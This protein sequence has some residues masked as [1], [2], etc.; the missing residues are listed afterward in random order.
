MQNTRVSKKY[1]G[2]KYRNPN[3]GRTESK[4]EK[5]FLCY[6]STYFYLSNELLALKI[7]QKV[8]VQWIFQYKILGKKSTFY[9]TSSLIFVKTPSYD[10]S[11]DWK[12][13]MGIVNNVREGIF[14][15]PGY[16][17]LKNRNSGKIRFSVFVRSEFESV[18]AESV[19]KSCLMNF[20]AE[21]CS[22]MLYYRTELIFSC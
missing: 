8:H 18:S 13:L 6:E 14:Q 15:K 11:N 19:F 16:L 10:T 12:L 2:K 5:H 20:V 22:N 9:D 21:T 7:R 17:R 4:P 3:F 1:P